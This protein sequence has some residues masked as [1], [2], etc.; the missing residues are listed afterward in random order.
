MLDYPEVKKNVSHTPEK[1]VRQSFFGKIMT[2]LFYENSFEKE[3]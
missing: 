2:F 3:Q 1:E